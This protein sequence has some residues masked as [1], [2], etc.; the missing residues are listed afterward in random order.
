MTNLLIFCA[1]FL[2]IDIAII[3]AVIEAVT[4]KNN[5]MKDFTKKDLIKP[6]QKNILNNK[7]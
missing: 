5:S 7:K 2:V 6:I 3:I 4:R 1:V